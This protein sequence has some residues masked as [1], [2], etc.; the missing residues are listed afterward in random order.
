[1][2][3]FHI[4][5]FFFRSVVVVCKNMNAT[6][7]ERLV[8]S[9][10]LPGCNP[11]KN[12]AGSRNPG[13]RNPE[14][15]GRCIEVGNAANQTQI[16]NG[17]A[18]SACRGETDLC[19]SLEKEA[20]KGCSEGQDDVLCKL[21]HKVRNYLRTR[22]NVTDEISSRSSSPRPQRKFLRPS[23]TRASPKVRSGVAQVS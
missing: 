10:S 8:P 22:Y 19:Q 5:S 17:A 14:H 9:L 15:K 16:A 20:Q 6:D 3:Y 13:S 1:M 7:V 21:M 2:T 11:G 18:S 4:I 23:S 12:P